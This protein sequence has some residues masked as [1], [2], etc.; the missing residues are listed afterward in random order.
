MAATK[1]VERGLNKC[2]AHYHVVCGDARTVLSSFP[3]RAV[4]AVV[5]S[6]PYWGMR[7]YGHLFEIGRED[8][9]DEYIKELVFTFEEV[10]RVLR[11]DGVVWL[12]LG[13]TYTSGNRRYRAT[14]KKLQSRAMNSRPKTPKGLKEKD[15]IGLP[16]RVAF[17]LQASGWYL[18]TDIVWAKPNPMP[19][20]VA[21]RPHRSHETI[22]ML[23]KSPKY[24]FDMAAF[25]SPTAGKG[26]FNRTVWTVAVGGGN[27]VHP[28]AFPLEL[29]Y[30]CVVSST[31]PGDVVLDPFAGSG[32]VGLACLRTGRRFAGIE[33][34]PEFAERANT[35]LSA[36]AQ[37][38]RLHLV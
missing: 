32:S 15:L 12:I 38:N 4:A 27:A 30:P 16:W 11:D 20:S 7:N 21:D 19:E 31:T 24:Y 5:T 1:V 8:T 18:R 37:Q 22:F 26:A 17:A 6:P 9:L 3:A 25:S 14:D 34:V 28:A 23:S 29:I 2:D 10:K 35:S 36:L 13:D 33:I